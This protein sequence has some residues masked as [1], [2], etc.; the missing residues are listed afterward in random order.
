MNVVV[1]E[2][3]CH[4]FTKLDK[5]DHKGTLTEFRHDEQSNLTNL[6]AWKPWS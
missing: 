1:E 3:V 5:L 6:W 2:A 4:G